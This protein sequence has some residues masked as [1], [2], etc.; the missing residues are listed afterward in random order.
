MRPIY[1]TLA[2]LLPIL[3]L[4]G[5]S[6]LSI[7]ALQTH[8]KDGDPAPPRPKAQPVVRG[9]EGPPTPNGVSPLGDEGPPTPN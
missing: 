3:T 2:I 5:V 6:I 7:G 8:P 9:D 4:L 1:A